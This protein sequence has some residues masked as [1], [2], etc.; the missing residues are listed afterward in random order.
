MSE[1]TNSKQKYTFFLFND[2]LAYGAKLFGGYYRFHR[3]LKVPP[4][5]D[6]RYHLFQP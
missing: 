4:L 6:R 5:S 1:K 2:A 3:L